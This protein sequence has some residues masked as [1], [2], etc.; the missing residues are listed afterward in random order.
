MS[1]D[2]NKIICTTTRDMVIL[3]NNG[4]NED[5][6]LCCRIWNC[7]INIELIAIKL[8]QKKTLNHQDIIF[9]KVEHEINKLDFYTQ[10]A[11]KDA[12]M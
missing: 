1:N 8:Y 10:R 4:E 6:A 7:P 5:N 12:I 9:L 3:Y 2:M 11:I